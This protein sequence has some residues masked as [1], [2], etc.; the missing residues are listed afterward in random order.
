MRMPSK[1]WPEF[2]VALVA[3]VVGGVLSF[4]GRLAGVSWQA[5]DDERHMWQELRHDAVKEFLLDYAAV[6]V[7][8]GALR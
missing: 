6:M 4:A 1:L 2:F 3:A 8:A 7:G 5:K